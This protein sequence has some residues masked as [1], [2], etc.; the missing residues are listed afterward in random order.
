[1]KGGLV[2]LIAGLIDSLDSGSGS[3][4]A[5]N[6][7]FPFV[8]AFLRFLLVCPESFVVTASCRGGEAREEG[9]ETVVMMSRDG[10][11][12][13]GDATGDGDVGEGEA[14]GATGGGNTK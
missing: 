10:D 3:C 9:G 13:R 12:A 4:A 14:E 6:L 5:F 1:M 7:P 8:L 11:L 2:G